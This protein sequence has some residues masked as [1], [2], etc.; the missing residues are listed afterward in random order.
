MIIKTTPSALTKWIGSLVLGLALVFTMY[1]CGNN[2][3]FSSSGWLKGDARARGRM[4]EDLVRSKILLGKTVEEAQQL[5][6]TPEKTYPTALQY[7]ID[8][9]YPFKDPSRYGLQVHF[10]QRRLV[11][12]AK[13]VD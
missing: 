9:G 10:D 7:Q 4:S 5:L 3:S 12:E 11:S 2:H 1:G 8:L 13:I 6:G